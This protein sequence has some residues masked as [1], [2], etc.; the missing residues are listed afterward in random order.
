[1]SLVLASSIPVLGL[2]RIC[3]RK[4]CPWPRIFCVLGLEPCVHDSTSIY[5]NKVKIR[6]D[7]YDF[8]HI[9]DRVLKLIISFLFSVLLTR[10]WDGVGDF[11]NQITIIIGFDVQLMRQ[12]LWPSCWDKNFCLFLKITSKKLQE[13]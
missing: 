4:G 2:E 11:N 9:K 8:T 6:S 12:I 13:A 1:M 10:E 7:A 5:Y 3:P